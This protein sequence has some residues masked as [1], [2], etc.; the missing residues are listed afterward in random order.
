MKLQQFIDRLEELKQTHGPDMP[1]LRRDDPT[2]ADTSYH[3][4]DGWHPEIIQAAHQ[5]GALQLDTW[6]DDRETGKDCLLLG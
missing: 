1:I 4:L 6:R 3:S 5:Q 2:R